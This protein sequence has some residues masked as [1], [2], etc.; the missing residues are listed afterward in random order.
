MAGLRRVFCNSRWGRRYL[1]C[2]GNAEQGSSSP[3]RR[4]S[5]HLDLLGPR[6]RGDDE[7]S[8][9]ALRLFEQQRKSVGLAG[10]CR[11][12]HFI[13]QRV[14][15]TAFHIAAI[16]KHGYAIVITEVVVVAERHHQINGFDLLLAGAYPW[17]A[18]ASGAAVPVQL[19]HFVHAWQ[20]ECRFE[21]VAVV[22]EIGLHGVEH[23][24]VAGF[25]AGRARVALDGRADGGLS[26][27]AGLDG[28]SY[29]PLARI[30]MSACCEVPLHRLRKS[31]CATVLSV[32]MQ[33][34]VRD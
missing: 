20:L 7:L 32:P 28:W 21:R 4:G 26:G 19:R 9:T 12:P 30:F 29:R 10:H 22:A 33:Y 14:F 34:M 13:L 8:S 17:N 27:S 2:P 24:L 11:I 25:V 16:D 3:R 31:C 23:A 5:S 1:P 6:F 15:L 18:L